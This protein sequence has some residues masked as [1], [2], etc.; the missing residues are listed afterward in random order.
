M[1]AFE[2]SL[3]FKIINSNKSSV[4]FACLRIFP[5][6]RTFFFK[7]APK[8]C[9]IL[10]KSDFFVLQTHFETNRQRTVFQIYTNGFC[11]GISN[12]SMYA[13]LSKC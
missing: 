11:F 9:S 7:M 13:E 3:L 6:R 10:I 8:T 4:L 1:L 2:V 12:E 5:C